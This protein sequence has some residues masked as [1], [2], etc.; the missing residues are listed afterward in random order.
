MPSS[1]ST[2]RRECVHLECFAPPSSIKQVWKNANIAIARS[3]CVCFSWRTGRRRNLPARKRKRRNA[4]C[5]SLRVNDRRISRSWEARWIEQGKWWGFGL[6]RCRK[7]YASWSCNPK[8]PLIDSEFKAELTGSQRTAELLRVWRQRGS[9]WWYVC[10]RT[11]VEDGATKQRLSTP[12]TWKKGNKSDIMPPQAS[13]APELS[14]DRLLE[15]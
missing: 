6:E 7:V 13:H 9:L 5:R 4:R 14:Q 11:V 1:L 8:T 3:D 12:K 10:I 2:G 15:K